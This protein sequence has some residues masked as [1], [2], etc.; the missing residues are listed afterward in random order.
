M[1]ERLTA[2][3]VELVADP[4]EDSGFADL[5]EFS[6]GGDEYD[7][8]GMESLPYDL[9]QFLGSLGPNAAIQTFAQFTE[10]TKAE[11]PFAPDGVLNY[12]A[13]F[14]EFEAC[15]ADASTPPPLTSFY[16][17]REA[18][19]T[20][21][22]EVMARFSLDGLVFPQMADPVP[23]RGAGI[24]IRET[25]VAELNIAGL[26]AVTV[27]AGRLPGGQPFNL[28]FVGRLWSEAL[29]LGMAHDFERGMA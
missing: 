16:A 12:L 28:I 3:G 17:V 13:G 20:I 29:L 1:Q 5:A 9:Q 14:A 8:R 7:P 18:Y 6:K 10:A 26:P 2:A 25:T 21:F 22:N 11:D 27:P 15:R 24:G 23:K 19:L 4:F